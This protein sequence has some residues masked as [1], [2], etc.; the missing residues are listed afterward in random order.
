MHPFVAWKTAGDDDDDDDNSNDDGPT[1][2]D[3]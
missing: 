2:N 3:G 1:D